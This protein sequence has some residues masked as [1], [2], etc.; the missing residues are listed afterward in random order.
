M[1]LPQIPTIAVV[2]DDGAVR[3]ALDNLLQSLGLGVVVFASAEEFLASPACRSAAC[4]IADV[5]MPGM[6]GIDLQRHLAASGNRL[7]IILVTAFPKEQV[8]A[9]AERE[10]AY[11]YFAKPFEGRQLIACIER[12]LQTSSDR[13]LLITRSPGS[14]D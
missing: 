13:H 11:G 12:A 5:Q 14:N 3:A 2:D 9:Q 1:T 4:L 10:G 6:S 7:P 8:R